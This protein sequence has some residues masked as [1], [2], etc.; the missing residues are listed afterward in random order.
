MLVDVGQVLA[1]FGDA[2]VVVG[3]W[4]PD[5]LLPDQASAHIGSID[6]D[7][8]LEMHARL[9]FVQ[10]AV[11]PIYKAASIV[12]TG[13]DWTRSL[14]SRYFSPVTTYNVLSIRV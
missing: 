3:G 1:S 7:L 10:S 2:I 6:V 9:S 12:T 4:V 13:K 5:L 11:P 8:A 14:G